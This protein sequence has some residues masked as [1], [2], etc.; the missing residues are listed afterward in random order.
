MAMENGPFINDYQI[1]IETS[2]QKPAIFQPCLMKPDGKSH[3]IPLNHHFPMVFL[4]SSYGFQHP[5]VVQPHGFPQ[6][7]LCL[8]EEPATGMTPP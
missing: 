5:M 3:K 1:A 7:G 2:I 4:W 6:L 8:V